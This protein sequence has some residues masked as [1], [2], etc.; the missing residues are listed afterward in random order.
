VGSFV[1]LETVRWGDLD[2]FQHLNNVAFQRYFETAWIQY[3]S[4]LDFFGD[5][6]A[7]SFFGMVLAEFHISYRAPVRFDETLEVELTITDVRRS[8]AR[9]GFE[10]RVGDRLCADGYGTYVGYD[11][12][13]RRAAPLPEQFRKKLEA[14]QI[15]ATD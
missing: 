7:D 2:A 11:N 13:N 9:V 6:F 15:A 4:Q 14:E 10:M 5:P 1:H 3:R 8:T 12:R